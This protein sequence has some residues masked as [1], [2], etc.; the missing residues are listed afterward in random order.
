MRV[1][2]T[3]LILAPLLALAQEDECIFD[4]TTQTDDFV[5]SVAEFSNYSWNSET[6]E[7]TIILPNAEV[8]VAH[9]GGCNH[10][11]ISGTLITNDSTNFSDLDHWF[12]RCLWIAERLFSENDFQSLKKSIEG[13]SYSMLE[14]NT[15]Y[16]SFPHDYYAEFYMT[17][18][19]RGDKVELYIGYY[20]S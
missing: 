10:F 8:L 1:I 2:L 5:K 20:F 16:I 19:K 4:Q 15:L 14:G 3:L 6:K 9:R 13:Q 17:L 18:K 12:E 11:G 7:A